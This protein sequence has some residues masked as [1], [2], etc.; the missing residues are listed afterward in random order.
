MPYL[1]TANLYN[2]FSKNIIYN[3]MK[4]DLYKYILLADSRFQMKMYTLH[5]IYIQLWLIYVKD[6]NL[7]Y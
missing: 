2:I 3:F 6:I 7:Y 4:V 1:N 5:L